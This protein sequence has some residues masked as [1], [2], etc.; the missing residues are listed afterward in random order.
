MSRKRNGYVLSFVALEVLE[1]RS[2]RPRISFPFCGSTGKAGNKDFGRS[3]LEISET[4]FAHAYFGPDRPP[5][6]PMKR[7]IAFSPRM[8]PL[9]VTLMCFMDP[10]PSDIWPGLARV[11]HTQ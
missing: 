9:E 11:L 8:R 7:S 6:I 1:T 10:G 3:D 4:L 2:Q 5:P